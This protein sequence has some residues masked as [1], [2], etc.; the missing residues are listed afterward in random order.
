MA[1]QMGAFKEEIESSEEDEQIKELARILIEGFMAQI[2]AQGS[3]SISQDEE[4]KPGTDQ[5]R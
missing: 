1:R 5:F 4:T 3:D 2:E